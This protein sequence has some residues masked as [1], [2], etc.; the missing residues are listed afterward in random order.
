MDH[1]TG[2]TDSWN[3]GRIYC[4]PVTR[5]LLLQHYPGLNPA[6]VVGLAV[7]ETHLIPLCA[8][9]IP[10]PYQPAAAKRA[11]AT[12]L[13]LHAEDGKRFAGAP[14]ETE[15]AGEWM[16]VTVLDARNHCPG[17]VMFLF[18]GSCVLGW[19][20]VVEGVGRIT[21]VILCHDAGYF[22]RILY[23]GDFRYEYDSPSSV[24]SSA[25]SASAAAPVP[26]S[27]YC[28]LQHA[29]THPTLHRPSLASSS[30]AASS[31]SSA[32]SASVSSAQL[33]SSAPIDTLYLDNTF[34]S[35]THHQH[36]LSTHSVTQRI[37]ALYQQFPAGHWLVLGVGSDRLGKE[38]VLVSVAHALQSMVVVSPDRY[39]ALQQLAEEG[40]D[41]VPPPPPSASS[42]M[43]ESGHKEREEYFRQ[44][45]APHWFDVFTTDPSKGFIHGMCV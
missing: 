45:Q 20:W 16:Q 36:F 21:D 23:T 17:A 35:S 42:S 10:S 5:S 13:L 15:T 29:L 32:A 33:I 43:N 31:S 41:L 14:A 30:A 44:F 18:E 28:P 24:V 34:L 19:V 40:Y 27:W 8:A 11:G 3:F 22:G 9:P 2:L 7:G 1:T 25:S 4:S 6:L 26:A 37:V 12:D 38:Q 39:R